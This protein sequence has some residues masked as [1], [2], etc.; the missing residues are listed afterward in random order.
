MT[1]ESFVVES[2]MAGG[3]S[4]GGS[5]LG[6]PELADPRCGQRIHM[7]IGMDQNAPCKA[8]QAAMHASTRGSREGIASTTSLPGSSK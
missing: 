5:V 2:E 4:R 8:A 3:L 7:G 1:F 6:K